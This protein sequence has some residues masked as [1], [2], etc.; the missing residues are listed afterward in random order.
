M[1]V[2]EGRWGSYVPVW[3]TIRVGDNAQ[4]IPH[5]LIGYKTIGAMLC[6]RKG[7]VTESL[8]NPVG[9]GKGNRGIEDG[10]KG[11]M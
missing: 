9:G 11:S 6:L 8:R 7:G 10:R 1:L 5:F 3:L 2:K 4:F